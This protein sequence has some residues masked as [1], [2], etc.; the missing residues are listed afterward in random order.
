MNTT[1]YC[2]NKTGSLGWSHST[3][4]SD[5]SLCIATNQVYCILRK[6]YLSSFSVQAK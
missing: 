6:H 1:N 4:V 3:I 2:R 5:L